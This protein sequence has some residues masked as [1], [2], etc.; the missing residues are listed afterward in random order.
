MDQLAGV[1]VKKSQE[2]AGFAP[3]ALGGATAD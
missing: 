3:D 1:R 2:V